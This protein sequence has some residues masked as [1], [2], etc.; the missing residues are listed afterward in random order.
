VAKVEGS[1]FQGLKDLGQLKSIEGSN[2]GN[3][4]RILMHNSVEKIEGLEY[5]GG[6]LI[7]KGENIKSLGSIKTITGYLNGIFNPKFESLGELEEV[8]ALE[9]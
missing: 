1:V 9:Y 2:G 7:L 5:V 4:L 8:G 3:L 6:D